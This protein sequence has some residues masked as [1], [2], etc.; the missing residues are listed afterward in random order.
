MNIQALIESLSIMGRGLLGIFA[1]MAALWLMIA[2]I[3]RAF[4]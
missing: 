1:V 2:L 4:R 3:R